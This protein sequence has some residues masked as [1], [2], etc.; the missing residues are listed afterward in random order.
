MPHIGPKIVYL[1]T[2]GILGQKESLLLD[3]GKDDYISDFVR[4][5]SFYN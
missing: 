5:L 4:R 3:L 1:S 2:V